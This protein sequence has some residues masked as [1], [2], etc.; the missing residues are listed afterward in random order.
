MP[1]QADLQQDIDLGSWIIEAL[2]DRHR[3]SVYQLGQL[4]LLLLSHLVPCTQAH[5][6]AVLG[7][8]Y[9][10]VEMQDL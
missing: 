8:A 9:Y 2:L 1:Q 5:R 6:P 4:Q 10:E 3:H 7:A